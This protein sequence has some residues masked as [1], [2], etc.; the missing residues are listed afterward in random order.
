MSE[1]DLRVLAF[2]LP[3]FHPIPENDEWW[4]R[5]FT[6]WINVARA[7]PQYRGHEQ[8]H[9]PAD[10]GFYDLRVPQVRAAQADL[11]RRHGLGGFCYYHYWFEGKRLLQRPFDEVLRSGEPDF[12]FCLCWANENWT[13]TWDGKAAD[14]LLR[15][16]YSPDDDLRHIRWLAEA[17]ADRRYI[18]VDG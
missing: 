14:V 3:Q 13:R 10:L 5:G 6:D 2:Y 18:R 16:T 15:Q 17:F 11:A 4:G 7:D 8:P 9:I 12:P 1:P